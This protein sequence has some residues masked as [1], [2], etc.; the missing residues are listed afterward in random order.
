M[1]KQSDFVLDSLTGGMNDTDPSHSLPDDMCVLAENVEFFFSTVGERRRGMEAVSLTGSTLNTEDVIVHLTTHVP[2][3]DEITDTE[4]WAVGA[5][6]GVSATVARR[7]AGVWSVVVPTDPIITTFPEVLQMQSQSIN[8]LLFVAY[9]SGVPRLH[10]W[11]GTVLRQVGIDAPAAAPGTA[12][13]AVAGTFSGDRTYRVRFTIMDGAAVLIRSEPSDEIT[14]PPTGLNDGVIITRPAIINE[15]ETHWELEASSGDG[16]F[17]VIA[18]LPIG[19]VSFTDT[20]EPGTDYADYVLSEEIGS[21]SLIPSVRFIK[22]DQNRLVFGGDWED[23]TRGSTL[24]WTLVSS[25]PGVG[26]YERLPV[27]TDNTLDL[28]MKGSGDLTG[29]SDPLN[30]SFYAFKWVGIYKIQRTG[31]ADDA[32]E[33]FLLSPARG[34]I[35]GSVISGMDEFGRGC[36]YFLDPAI[37]PARISTAG[38]QMIRGNRTTWRRVNTAAQD[39]ISHGVYYP[40]KQQVHW[41]LATDSADSP[42]LEI[43]LQVNEVRSTAA[44]TERGWSTATATRATAWCSTIVPE[45]NVD[46]DTGAT[47]LSFRPYIGLEDPHFI[48]RVD[49]GYTDNGQPYRARI[50][51]KPY[52]SAGL[53]NK[54]GTMSAALLALA[55]PDLE[56]SLDVTL[57]RDFGL[58]TETVNTDFVPERDE[59]LVIKKL[60]NLSLS[61]AAA[62]QVEFSD[63]ETVRGGRWELHRFDMKPRKEG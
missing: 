30:G 55:N 24:S 38:L 43:V 54:W 33:S 46:E 8:G 50:L 17:Y 52:L 51:T 3:E 13:T 2:A 59:T 35:P 12:D 56:I 16:N 28:G 39:V 44:G 7:A 15:G 45:E 21:Y 23:P 4:L 34:A 6:N 27:N 47:S 29:I 62:I 31:N 1:A 48:Q 53:L 11:D 42:N 41:W 10:V 49:L 22:Q 58:G 37:G 14:H 60:D 61:E 25:S 18:T 57:I 32:Y 63:R 9:K 5:T 19:T 26:N 20:T 36:I 40:D